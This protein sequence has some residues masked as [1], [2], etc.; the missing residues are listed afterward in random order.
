[1]AYLL[2]LQASIRIKYSVAASRLAIT[3]D[4]HENTKMEDDNKILFS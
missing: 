4:N 1:M 3:H 2:G